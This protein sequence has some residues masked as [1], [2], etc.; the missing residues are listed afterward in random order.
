M[1]CDDRREIHDRVTGVGG[2]LLLAGAIQIASRPNAGSR[3]GTPAHR[4]GDVAGS[5]A[6][7]CPTIRD[8][9]PICTPLSSTW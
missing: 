3:V 9:D 5:I 4:L 1:R 6:S 2:L 7:R 8:P